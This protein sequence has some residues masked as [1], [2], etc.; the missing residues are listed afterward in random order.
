MPIIWLMMFI[1]FFNLKDKIYF[2]FKF[3]F[4]FLFFISIPIIIDFIKYPLY[5]LTD[6]Y[7]F[8]DNISAVIVLTGGAYKDINNNWYPSG[9]TIKRAVL[10]N[11]IAKDLGVPLIISG[12]NKSPDLPAESLL[13]SKL[14][15]NQNIILETKS[16]NTYQSAIN[17]EEV[18]H[19]NNLN[20]NGKFLLIT[21]NMH[22]LRASLTFESQRYDIKTYNYKSLSKFNYISFIPNSKSFT[23]FNH[24]LYEYYGIIKYIILGHIKVNI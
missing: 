8:G 1:I 9:I 12:G 6:K 22:N 7:S 11:N 13:V 18:L 15:Q 5:Q 24:C 20:K 3:I 23:F 17:L 16:K 21:S 14:F 4:I 2:Y 19:R 10:G